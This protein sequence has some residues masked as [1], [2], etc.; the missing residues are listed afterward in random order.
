MVKKIAYIENGKNRDEIGGIP[1]RMEAKGFVVDQFWASRME[2]P[3]NTSDYDGYFLSGSAYGA[4]EDVEFIHKEH[5]FLQE[6]AKTDI[7]VLGV[8]FG[9]QILA[10]ALCDRDQVFRRD[11]CHVGYLKMDKTLAANEDLLMKDTPQNLQ[12][13]IWHNDQIKHKH[14]DMVLL[15]T[16]DEAPNQIW[17][18]KNK[19]IWGIQGHPEVTNKIAAPWLEE[20]RDYMIKDGADVDELKRQIDEGET[21]TK[22]LDNFLEICLNQE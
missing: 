2:F 9:S 20:V 11:N 12:M 1:E 5:E 21:G 10:S 17:R 19:K 8:C 6:L 4:Y 7:P 16:T 18:Y 13:L 14:P 3:E 22:L 15:A